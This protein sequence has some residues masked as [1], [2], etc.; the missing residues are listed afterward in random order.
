MALAVAH[1]FQGVPGSARGRDGLE[2][3]E[4]RKLQPQRAV[5]VLARLRAVQGVHLEVVLLEGP[6]LQLVHEDPHRTVGAIPAHARLQ[7]R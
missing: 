4:E 6:L 2:G 5:K 1:R 3:V 7:A